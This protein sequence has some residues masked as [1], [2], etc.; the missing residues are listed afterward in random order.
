MGTHE[1]SHDSAFLKGLDRGNALNPIG[2]RN[3]RVG[4]DIDLYELQPS[5]A[6]RSLALQDGAQ[7]PAGRAPVSPEVDH[8]G[9]RVGAVENR[10]IEVAL[11]DIHRKEVTE[12]R[13]PSVGRHGN[14]PPILYVQ[15]CEGT[16]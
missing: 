4:I 15:V 8:H 6:L 5:R 14:R 13:G 1:L 16:G 3:G 10:R 2:P 7:L 9:E 12:N 11:G